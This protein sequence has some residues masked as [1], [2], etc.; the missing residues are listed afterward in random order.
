MMRL[1]HPRVM[2]ANLFPR[3]VPE[4]YISHFIPMPVK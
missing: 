2:I 4:T 1:N 3:L